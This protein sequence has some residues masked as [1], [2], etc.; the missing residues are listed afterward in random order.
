MSEFAEATTSS[1]GQTPEDIAA[2]VAKRR[3][4]LQA[5]IEA[6]KAPVK[7]KKAKPVEGEHKFWNTQ[8]II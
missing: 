5:L 6:K 2:E 1:K 4:A 8:V 3:A 7:T